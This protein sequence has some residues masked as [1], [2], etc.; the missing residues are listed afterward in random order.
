MTDKSLSLSSLCW[1]WSHDWTKWET[2]EKGIM[3][4]IRPG[5]DPITVGVYEYQRRVC[6]KCGQ[7]QLREVAA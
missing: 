1:P 6:T 3:Q 7:S 2:T 4:R 5:F